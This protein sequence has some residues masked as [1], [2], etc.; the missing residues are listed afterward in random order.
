MIAA[1]VFD[2]YGVIISDPMWGLM[3]RDYHLQGDRFH[4]LADDVNLGHL[5][6]EKFE[7]ELAAATGKSVKEISRAYK[8]YRVNKDVIT[9][10]KELNESYKVGLLT[11][12]SRGHFDAVLEDLGAA[13][14][15]DSIVVSAD[16]AMIKPSPGIYQQSLRELGVRAAEAVFID[17]N[18]FNVDGAKA[19][20]MQ[21]IF[22]KDYAQM[23]KELEV[24]L[25]R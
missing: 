22:Y 21:G 17:D 4:K 23:K 7:Q 16:I 19:V 25:A 9:L 24:L 12:A 6:W 2:F 20:G 15:F 1:V 5:S 3:K 8:Q 10:I 14:L 18:Q 11:N 13:A